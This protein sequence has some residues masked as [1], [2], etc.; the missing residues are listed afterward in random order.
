MVGVPGVQWTK[1]DTLVPDPPSS[2]TIP[3]IPNY[4]NANK[5]IP[6]LY[7]SLYDCPPLY[8]SFSSIQLFGL[9]QEP[10]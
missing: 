1:E 7:D 4:P 9:V 8:S 2:T 3:I 6:K 5:F 10:Y